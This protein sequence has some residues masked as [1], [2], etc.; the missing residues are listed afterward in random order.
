MT[1][2]ILWIKVHKIHYQGTNSKGIEYFNF[3]DSFAS[4]NGQKSFKKVLNE[5]L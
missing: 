4:V 1:N 5:S 3:N 2:I